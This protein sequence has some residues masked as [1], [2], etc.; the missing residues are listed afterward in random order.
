[1]KTAEEIDRERMRFFRAPEPK[2]IAAPGWVVRTLGIA[3]E[4]AAF[5]AALRADNKPAMAAVAALA[6]TGG[7][8]GRSI[9]EVVV[10]RGEATEGR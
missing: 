4:G 2:M 5:Y 10:G 3:S 6:L 9:R 1:V 7:V 8:T